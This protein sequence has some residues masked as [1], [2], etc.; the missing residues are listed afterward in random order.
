MPDRVFIL[1]VSHFCMQVFLVDILKILVKSYVRLY[2]GFVS[3]NYSVSELVLR[4]LKIYLFYILIHQFL[5]LCD[6][7][8]LLV[9]SM[10][11]VS[12]IRG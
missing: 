2:L 9:V 7:L 5:V 4:I 6:V 12:S 8:G 11:L 1:L 10:L 3:T